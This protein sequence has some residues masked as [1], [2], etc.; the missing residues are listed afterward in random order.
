MN[1]QFT[2]NRKS[3][4]DVY[5]PQLVGQLQQ[6]LGQQGQNALAPVG[7]QP[8][9]RRPSYRIPTDDNQQDDSLNSPDNVV[10]PPSSLGVDEDRPMRRR[11][12]QL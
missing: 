12:S 3:A 11:G 9:S 7:G 10:A 6:A 1:N 4:Y 5:A 8:G 2:S